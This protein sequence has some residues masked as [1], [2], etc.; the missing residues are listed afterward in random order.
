[1]CTSV[2]LP[3][4]TSLADVRITFR[5]PSETA[6]C[7][8]VSK[9]SHSVDVTQSH[10]LQAAGASKCTHTPLGPR[11][12]TA[13]H[14]VVAMETPAPP[15]PANGHPRRRGSGAAP[16][17]ALGQVGGPSSRVAG[18]RGAGGR[19]E[20]TLPPAAA[21]RP[22][23]HALRTKSAAPRTLGCALHGAPGVHAPGGRA[24]PS[25]RRS[26]AADPIPRAPPCGRAQTSSCRI[27]PR[28]AACASRSRVRARP[29]PGL[30][31]PSIDCGGWARRRHL[32]GDG[33]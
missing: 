12:L 7:V 16:R 26:T 22:R 29:G 25:A 27:Q 10:L 17:I 20:P 33:A 30:H 18:M 19:G 32:R 11:R 13:G 6:L 14:S 28:E 1:V 2:C 3:E 15:R 5:S 9:T 24:C 21:V 8:S 4:G 23:T 31:P